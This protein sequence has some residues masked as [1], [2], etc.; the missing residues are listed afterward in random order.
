LQPSFLCLVASTAGHRKIWNRTSSSP[1]SW[2]KALRRHTVSNA[3]KMAM[4]WFLIMPIPI[5][6]FMLP[7]AASLTG[8]QF[9]K[10]WK[11]FDCTIPVSPCT[12]TCRRVLRGSE[13]SKTLVSH[14]SLDEMPLIQFCDLHRMV[15]LS[16]QTIV[17]GAKNWQNKLQPNVGFALHSLRFLN[18]QMRRMAAP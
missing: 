3:E 8:Q 1:K 7:A 4:Q 14:P 15:S 6:P 9:L 12:V 10:R 13:A 11:Q 2:T 16:H 18:P 5:E 17:Q